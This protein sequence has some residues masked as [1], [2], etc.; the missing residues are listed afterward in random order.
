MKPLP[1]GWGKQKRKRRV[2]YRYRRSVK[3]FLRFCRVQ[4]V[5]VLNLDEW[6][7]E[8]WCKFNALALQ[9]RGSHLAQLSQRVVDSLEVTP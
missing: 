3:R 9:L 5:N 1:N 7:P 6:T 8:V 2:G 4:G